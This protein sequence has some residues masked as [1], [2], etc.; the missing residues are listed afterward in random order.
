[1]ARTGYREQDLNDNE[2]K[3]VKADFSMHFRPWANTFEIILQHK[4]GLGNTIYQ[5]ANRYALKNFF[6]NQSK[7][8]VKGKNFFVR[9]YMTAENAG[10]SYDMR[11]AAWNV[12]RAWKSDQTWFGQYA[13]AFV[14]ATLAGQ[15]PEVAHSIGRATADT[16]RFLPGSAEFNDALKTI[17]NNPDLTE[18]AK[19]KDQSKLYHSDVNYN[20]KD[21][22]KFAEFQLGGSY[23][24]Y[25]MNSDGTI[26]T[27][28]DGPIRYD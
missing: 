6:M 20:F 26:F 22:I 1:M 24:Q 10:D 21:I 4:I 17:S 18:G 23:R 27:D 14:Q 28:Y 12:N 15:S 13:G 25:E 5:G 16:D 19:F 11:F 3:S 9:G 8:E 7:I 2:V